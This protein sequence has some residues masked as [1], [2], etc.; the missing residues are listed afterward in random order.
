[1]KNFSSF[2]FLKKQR[3]STTTIQSTKTSKIN[4]I[5]TQYTKYAIKC[6][7][8]RK[9]GEILFTFLFETSFSTFLSKKYQYNENEVVNIELI[10]SL[11]NTKLIDINE[12]KNFLN[13][14]LLH[15]ISEKNL[16]N[17]CQKLV[18]FGA[19][20]LLEDNYRQTP[21][22]IAAKSNYF[23]LVKILCN[24]IKLQSQLY[25]YENFRDYNLIKSQQIYKA[26]YYA[27]CSNNIEIAEYLFDNFS[28]YSEQL[29]FDDNVEIVTSTSSDDDDEKS[30][31]HK[32]KLKYELNSYTS[33]LNALHVAAYNSYFKV[34]KHLIKNSKNKTVYINM[35]INKFRESTPLEEA[36]KGLLTLNFNYEID[37]FT[38]RRKYLLVAGEYECKKKFKREAELEYKFIINYLIENGAKFSQNFLVNNDFSRIS[39]QIFYGEFKHLNLIHFINCINFLFQYKIDE[40]FQFNPNSLVMVEDEKNQQMKN[41]SMHDCLNKMFNEL[42]HHLYKIVLKILKDY[43]HLCIK[44]YSQLIWILCNEIANGKIKLSSESFFYLK[45]RNYELY[46]S[47]STKLSNPMSLQQLTYTRIKSSIKNFGIEKVNSLNLP[48]MLKLNLLPEYNHINLD[49]F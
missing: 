37:L 44:L 16:I 29:Q 25:M 31:Q 15:I 23:E 7:D 39:Q 30:F 6:N 2:K 32:I 12:I 33:E 9:L 49:L 24:S 48:N 20:C 18:D 26:A 42:L 3:N 45:E 27:C 47:I 22:L 19:N 1:M 17:V 21:L 5:L 28:L 38:N 14:T 34:V 8:K 46:E 36:F 11:L 4:E 10:K 43:K 41:M 40:L 13:Q 35:A